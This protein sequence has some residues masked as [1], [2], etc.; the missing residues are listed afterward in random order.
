MSTGSNANAYE[1]THRSDWRSPG[2][3]TAETRFNDVQ[4]HEL[5]RS[6]LQSVKQAEGSRCRKEVDGG[7]ETTLMSS[8]TPKRT[9][10]ESQ[11][12]QGA[13]MMT[14]NLKSVVKPGKPNA[15]GRFIII[16]GKR[17]A[18]PSRK[19]S[20]STNWPLDKKVE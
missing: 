20:L 3:R 16:R 1:K 14:S 8:L 19:S 6:G 5:R 13:S 7:T 18:F 11:M 15:K 10:T 17:F 12:S 9:K 4:I 2:I